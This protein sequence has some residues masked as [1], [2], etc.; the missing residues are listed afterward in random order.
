MLSIEYQPFLL[1]IYG[2]APSGHVPLWHKTHEKFKVNATKKDYLGTS[3]SENN[4]LTE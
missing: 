4:R 1:F 2:S 3:L